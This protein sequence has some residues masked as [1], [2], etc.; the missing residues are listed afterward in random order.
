[1]VV[2]AGFVGNIAQVPIPKAA[3]VIE[4]YWHIV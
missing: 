4:L 1:M 3:V 2:A